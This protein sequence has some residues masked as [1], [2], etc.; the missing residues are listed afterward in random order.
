MTTIK[1]L[2][3]FLIL[4]CIIVNINAGYLD[5]WSDDELCGW[6]DNPTPPE[7]I[8]K[9]VNKRGV[10]CTSGIASKISNI[11]LNQG[12]QPSETSGIQI[13][14]IIFGEDILE[15]LLAISPEEKASDF[16]R[17][18]KNY[19]LAFIQDEITCGFNLKRVVYENKAEGEIEDW[20]MAYGSIIFNGL[21]ADF[22]GSWSKGMGGFSSDP[23]YFKDEI[24]IK[25]TKDGHL[26]GKMAYFTHTIS[27]NEA[28]RR[29][30]FIELKKNL[31]SKPLNYKNIKIDN[32]AEFWIDVEDWAGG[33]MSL[34]QCKDREIIKQKVET[35][36]ATTKLH[37]FKIE[38]D[39]YKLTLDKSEFME[40]K[41]FKL[42]RSKE[43][44]KTYQLH[45]SVIF[46]KL[47]SRIDDS[48]II[49]FNTLV[50]KQANTQD[51]KLVIHVD[52]PTI[53]SLKRHKDSLENKCGSKV[54]EYGWL[55]FISQTADIKS[56]KS[57]QCKYDYFKEAND[58][59]AMELF[60][61]I[62][63]GTESIL[64]YLNAE[65]IE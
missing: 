39:I 37:I 45:K 27:N 52:D 7:Y 5:D 20:D 26:V 22:I 1:A 31:K 23:R 47:K 46:G 8:V 10:S 32:S 13:Y 9:E 30:L 60:Q 59:E 38:N 63:G 21:N 12:N 11:S 29:P 24:N 35:K 40:T 50:F 17:N 33:V 4:N 3:C 64:D 28:P 44:L 6:M 56:A 2:T 49:S 15:E 41:P 53:K 18:F 48:K 58:N 55:S 54:M 19:R 25:L 51:Q 57:Q 43:Y 61:A 65:V 14:D 16:T 36:K 34:F 42:E 62:L